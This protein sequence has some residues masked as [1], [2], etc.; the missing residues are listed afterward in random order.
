MVGS[1]RSIVALIDQPGAFEQPGTQ[2]RIGLSLRR[3]EQRRGVSARLRHARHVYAQRGAGTGRASKPVEHSRG[4]LDRLALGFEL[5]AQV[6]LRIRV[7][8]EF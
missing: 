1:L 7:A 8:V 4:V 2:R 3:T 5:P 6:V